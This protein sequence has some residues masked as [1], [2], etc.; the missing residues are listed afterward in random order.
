MTPAT[1]TRATRAT[2]AAFSPGGTVTHGA[3]GTPR[4]NAGEIRQKTVQLHPITGTPLRSAPPQACTTAEK[5]RTLALE[6][7]LEMRALAD[8]VHGHALAIEARTQNPLIL[9]HVSE[10]QRLVDEMR[11]LSEVTAGF[12][13]ACESRLREAQERRCWDG[14][15]DLRGFTGREIA[16]FLKPPL[17]AIKNMDL[18]HLAEAR[19]MLATW[20]AEFGEDIFAPHIELFEKRR[21]VL[22]AEFERW[23]ATQVSA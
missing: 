14:L 23:Q 6:P 1:A 13:D 20:F 15:A 11:R 4:R 22:R 12:L 3:Q 10:M 8:F 5:V 18:A 9:E 21:R 2:P 19:A 16:A 7:V 17:D